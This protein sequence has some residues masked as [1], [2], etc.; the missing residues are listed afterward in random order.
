LLIITINKKPK[1]MSQLYLHCGA[2]QANY[3]DL[4]KIETPKATATWQPI[5]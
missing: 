2:C 3:E 1:N 4:A 5:G